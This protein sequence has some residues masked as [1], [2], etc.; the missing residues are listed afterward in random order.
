MWRDREHS[1]SNPMVETDASCE[2]GSRQRGIQRLL[3]ASDEVVRGRLSGCQA[4]ASPEKE[5]EQHTTGGENKGPE[6]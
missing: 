2:E 5:A 6:A 4:G 3:A 1:T